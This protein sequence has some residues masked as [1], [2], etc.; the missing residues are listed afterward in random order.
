M[1]HSP[2][3]SFSK[4]ER[5][6]DLINSTQHCN[7][8]PRMGDSRK[9][10]SSANGNI[11]SKVLFVAEA[12]GRL[13]ADRTG[14]P[15][16]GDRTGDNFEILLGNIGWQREDIFI[17]NA[18]L[19]N[20]KQTNGNN[21][22]PTNLEIANCSTYLEMVISLVSPTVI[23]TLGVTALNA[24]SLISPHGL[25]LRRD[26][27]KIS[28]WMGRQIFPLYHPSPRA[29]IH[30]SLAKQRSDYMLL[31]KLV[32]PT[33]GQIKRN[34][35]KT[36]VQTLF[37]AESSK[38]QQ[39]A[40]YLLQLSGSMSYF[41]MTKLIYLIDLACLKKLG[42]TFASDIYLR[43]VDG[44]WSPD[45]DK[46]LIAMNGHEVRRSYPK[47]NY[48]MVEL[49]PSPR[50]EVS[51]E[52]TV[53]GIISDIYEKYGS[54]SNAEIKSVAYLSEPMKFILRKENKGMKMTNRPVIYKNKTIKELY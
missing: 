8:C 52:D 4:N 50:F 6:S 25:E 51:I 3:Q 34:K 44:P 38:I 54:L 42:H 23:V 48:P 37:P 24:L 7:L 29:M 40:R 27:A 5:F 19:C 16:Y 43:Q 15:L 28:R 31:A 21:D 46:A 9:V 18:I 14:V 36:Y 33:K 20:P 35:P 41:K 11:D 47:D 2:Y 17:T 30:R 45:L 12:P 13:G 22:T 39:V 1:L 53:L 26:V 10:L 32:Q 49:G